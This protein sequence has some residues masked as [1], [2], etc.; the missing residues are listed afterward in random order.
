MT[1]YTITLKTAE[2]LGEINGLPAASFVDYGGKT[3]SGYTK[4]ASGIYE[5]CYEGMFQEDGFEEADSI[6]LPEE[7]AVVEE[8]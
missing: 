8:E 2:E 1:K 7:I 3:L 6:F 5:G 4:I